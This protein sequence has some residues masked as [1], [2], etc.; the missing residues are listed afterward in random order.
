[1]NQRQYALIGGASYLVIF[2]TAIFGNFV[3][4]DTLLADP[5]GTMSN[6]NFNVRLGIM[7][8]LIAG[9]FD[10]LVA[11]ALYA[12]YPEHP[13]T[14]VS[15]WFRIMHAGI[16]GVAVYTLVAALNLT[17][18]DAILSA[19]HD[20]NTIWLIGLFFFGVHLLFLGRIVKHIRIVPF[21]LMAAGAMYMIDTTAHFVLVNYD[22]YADIFLTLVAIPSIVGEMAFGLYLLAKAGKN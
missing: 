20:F 14:P 22:A 3:V 19:V 4:L 6:S 21:F 2:V 11:W 1:M 9:L 13:F 5:T 12:L 8:F 16:M 17:D 7:A 10:V 15:T 18:G